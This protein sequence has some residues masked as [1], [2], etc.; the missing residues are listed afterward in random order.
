MTTDLA[1]PP[2]EAVDAT[3]DALA[4]E[5]ASLRRQVDEQADLVR[6]GTMAA[7]IAHEFHNVLTPIKGHTQ[8]GLAAMKN[9]GG[10]MKPARHA[11]RRCQ[12]A[13]READALCGSILALARP[14]PTEAAATPVQRAVDEAVAAL[15]RPPEDDSI[16]LE[17]NVCDGLELPMAEALATHVVLNLLLNA[18]KAV[19]ARRGKRLICVVGS[20]IGARTSLSVIDDGVGMAPRQASQCTRPFATGGGGSGLGLTLV[21]SACRRVGGRVS[22]SS[23]PSEGTSVTLSFE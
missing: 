13:A 20:R 23:K 1:P 14:G 10:Q 17:I 19:R 4:A 2:T 8:L 18:R 15:P 6:L 21:E 9:M 22:V 12:V 11:L 16:R 5:L 7:A 3:L